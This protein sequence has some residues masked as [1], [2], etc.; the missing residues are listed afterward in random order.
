MTA[1]PSANE[2]CGDGVNRVLVIGGGLAGIAAALTALDAGESVTLLEAKRHLGGRAASLDTPDGLIDNGQ[3]LILDACV[4]T[5]KLLQRLD[6]E[7]CWTRLPE[8]L[9]C[10]PNRPE[11]AAESP[12][13]PQDKPRRLRAVRFL[14]GRLKFL[15][16]LAALP[17][18]WRDKR[19]LLATL[20]R[21]ERFDGEDL[22]FGDFLAAAQADDAARRFF[23]EPVILSAL[24]ESPRFVSTA[25]A[26]QV[27]FEGFLD[28]PSPAPL[29]PNVP[30]REI[31]HV[32]AAAAL[33]KAGCDVRLLTRVRR[34]I[35][36]EDGKKIVACET[37]DRSVLRCE[38]VVLAAE[39]RGCAR[40]LDESF[41]DRFDDTLRFDRLQS[42]AITAFHLWLDRRIA[43]SPLVLDGAPGQWLFVPPFADS[44]VG[45]YHQVL[46]SGSHRL[47]DDPARKGSPEGIASVLRQLHRL[48]PSADVQIR[49]SRVVTVPDAVTLPTPEMY[50]Q[51]PSG[52]TPFENLALAGDWTRTGW[53][54]TLEGAIRSGQ[55]AGRPADAKI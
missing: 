12:C 27:I 33:K 1:A 37:A 54:S 39:P 17:F 15:P 8:I 20:F 19:R 53:P 41:S 36:S 26:R 5:K 21:L 49:K 28:A 38:R 42:G 50:A 11:G 9:L 44:D 43:D 34:L 22:S 24:C 46:V 7:N 13:R 6:A 47:L 51:R 31:C 40:L 30:L 3:H 29:L 25:A 10:A 52:V 2:R 23:W 4:E 18:S 32:R 48:F 16:A 45:V 14:P 35:V 55:R